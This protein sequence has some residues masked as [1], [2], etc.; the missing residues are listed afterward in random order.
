MEVQNAWLWRELE[1]L[2]KENKQ[3]KKKV[4]LQEPLVK[5]GVVVG[6]N[7]LQGVTTVPNKSTILAGFY[8]AHQG[9]MRAD[10]STFELGYLKHQELVPS[11]GKPET[12]FEATYKFLFNHLHDLPP[13]TQLF[14]SDH[15]PFSQETLE[16][17]D[18]LV[19]MKVISGLSPLGQ[20][21][22]A[23]HVRFD[24]L[25]IQVSQRAGNTTTITSTREAEVEPLF[26][27]MRGI[28]EKA[29]RGYGRWNAKRVAAGWDFADSE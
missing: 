23:D 20:E 10:E 16:V 25:A 4:E 6:R 26:R 12:D 24:A 1:R 14:H 21:E 27:E 19:T 15:V 17:L 2:E 5:V 7:F 13:E 3:L 22:Q 8:A 28:V 9:N 11:P 29:S 18:M